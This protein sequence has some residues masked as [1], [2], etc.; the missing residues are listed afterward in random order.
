MDPGPPG[1]VICSLLTSCS[2]PV[3][4]EASVGA[5]GTEHL[6]PPGL[7]KPPDTPQR[8]FRLAVGGNTGISL[9]G[10]HLD[11]AV[12]GAA[13]EVLPRIAPVKRRDPGFMS[14]Q[15]YNML[16][17]LHVVDGYDAG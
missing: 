15:V 11:L 3:E 13:E 14:R 1:D 2:L 9:D 10:P 12:E 17:V 8:L 5:S 4:G 7:W 16:A 6:A